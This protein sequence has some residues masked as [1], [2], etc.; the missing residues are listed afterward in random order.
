[1]DLS[2]HVNPATGLVPLKFNHRYRN[3]NA[4]EIAGFPPDTAAALLAH[5]E[6]PCELVDVSVKPVPVA[7]NKLPEPPKKSDAKK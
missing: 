2:K 6:G 5:K 7:E 3:I 4:G 1:M